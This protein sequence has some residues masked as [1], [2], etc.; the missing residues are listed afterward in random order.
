MPERF[1]RR[2]QASLGIY[3]TLLLACVGAFI[4]TVVEIARF[5]GLDSDALE[6]TNLAEESL[7]AGYQPV[8][9]SEYD[10]FWLDGCFGK[11]RFSLEAGEEE[12]EALLYDN[13]WNRGRNFYKMQVEEVTAET[14]LLATDREG[15]VFQSQ[16]AAA[17]KAKF[18]EIA[19][20]E[21]LGRIKGIQDA[22]K[23]GENPED[24]ISPAESTLDSIRQQQETQEA[25]QQQ[26]L[27][28]GADVKAAPSPFGFLKGESPAA[29]SGGNPLEANRKLRSQGGLSLVLPK[30]AVLSEKTVDI[31]DCLLKRSCEKGTDG[32]AIKTGTAD[33]IFMQQYIKRYG[34][35]FLEPRVSG[36]LSYG[37]EYVIAG[38][39][40][41]RENLEYVVKELLLVREIANFTY[42]FTDEAKQAQ[43]L[44]AATALAGISA[45]PPLIEVV[46][47]GILAVW[48]YGESICDVKI[49]LSGG[50]VPL[51]KTAAE[52]NTDLANIG[53][54]ESGNYS[55]A[56]HG[57]G[58]EDYLQAFL[59]VLST[60]TASY[61]C[62]D[63][64]EY[65]M[66][67]S[68]YDYAKMDHM[69]LRMKIQAEYSADTIFSSL[70][71]ED[72]IGGYIFEKESSYCYR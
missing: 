46:K 1:K 29:A 48:A 11:D 32:G 20:E 24:K 18:G 68:G 63:L 51:V 4:L 9:L 31:G 36:G 71:G 50:K 19:A 2:C 62:M 38:K 30:G 65:T 5:S 40:T 25:A 17:Y 14:C 59:Y 56:D 26:G 15:K 12:M 43:A 72:T 60:K 33:R 35:N 6:Y 61:R 49:L 13:L 8:L 44:A 54:V 55:G 53:D 47:Q 3:F 70:L 27:T 67:K 69:I 22:K 45:N 37:E 16:A 41:D 58:Y 39:K 57:L 10:M 64:M 28:R 42:L 52:W 21:I 7:F 66:K 23:R 34:G